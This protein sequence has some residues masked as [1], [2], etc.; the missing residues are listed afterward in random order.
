MSFPT[1]RLARPLLAILLV[2]LP[3]TALRAETPAIRYRGLAEGRAEAKAG[4]K[5]MLYLFTAAWC[6]SCREM[7]LGLASNGEVAR[8]VEERF[9]PIEVVD[10]KREDG[11]NAPEVQELL[12][13]FRVSGLPTLVVF[14]PDGRAAVRQPGFTTCEE[15]FAFLRE[16]LPRL[17][18]AEEKARRVGR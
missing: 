16:A 13:G 10:R 12:D 15:T 1:P 8:L 6:P 11:A 4:G 18:A 7:K 14:R 9:V 17:E 2:A 3:A 5:P